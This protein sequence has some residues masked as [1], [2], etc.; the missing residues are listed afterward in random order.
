MT[1]EYL[2]QRFLSSRL[3][4]LLSKYI[5]VERIFSGMFWTSVGNVASS[6][7]TF[8]SS[9]LLA[10]ILGVFNFGQ[11]SLIQ[12][13]LA[14]FMLMASPS[15]GFLATKYIAEHKHLNPRRA[16]AVLKL[17]NI[18]ALILSALMAV[19]LLLITPYLAEHIMRTPELRPELYLS[20]GILL[21]T[22]VNGAQ[23]GALAG[24]EAFKEVAL[25]NIFKGLFTLI[26]VS[27]G[28][29]Y[30]GIRGA[31]AGLATVS[32]LVC[33]FSN[34]YVAKLT[35]KH[36]LPDISRMDLTTEM[37]LLFSF[38]LPNWLFSVIGAL[39]NVWTYIMLTRIPEGFAQMGIFNAANQFFLMLNFLP[40]IIWQVSFPVLSGVAGK[41]DFPKLL[42]SYRKLIAINIVVIAGGFCLMAPVA[43]ILMSK[44]G[45]D[46]S[47]QLPTLLLMLATTL[48]YSLSAVA[49][50]IMIVLERMWTS[51]WLSL[52]TSL[53][54]VGI[55]FIFQDQGA[56]GLALAKLISYI[57]YTIIGMTCI[58]AILAK[59]IKT[60]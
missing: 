39:V 4:K 43:N 25:I 53:L 21:F 30:G 19:T 60:A 13:T 5:P 3:C 29:Y 11:F 32:L 38:S 1:Q 24:F 36:N 23:L 16:A 15:L 56:Y 7:A 10:K 51:L 41:N 34:Y 59:K 6:F 2:Q 9:L 37:G 49:W 8:A 28:G 54:Y 42:R 18:S 12:G 20:A 45:K 57:V 35:A 33:V 48:F 47:G 55:F 14:V 58:E 44:L 52:T 26:L 40:M 17:T 46:F 27:L 31:I 22:G 50:Q